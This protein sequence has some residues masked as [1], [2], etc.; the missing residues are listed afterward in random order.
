MQLKQEVGRTKGG[1]NIITQV[2]FNEFLKFFFSFFFFFERV[3]GTSVEPMRCCEA[4]D[5][6]EHSRQ[7]RVPCAVAK[8]YLRPRKR[9]AP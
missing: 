2:V 9:N 3:E 5:Y 6:I 8:G 4:G 1:L 7:E